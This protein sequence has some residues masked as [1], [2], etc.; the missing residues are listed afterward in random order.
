M[1]FSVF[2]NQRKKWNSRLVALPVW[3]Q[4]IFLEDLKDTIEGRFAVFEALA[5]KSS[6]VP[7]QES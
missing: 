6:D 4:E 2:E 5:K 7:Q 1:K 3:M